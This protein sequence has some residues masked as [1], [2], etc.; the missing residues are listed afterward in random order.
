MG[1]AISRRITSANSSAP[2]AL[3]SDR[4]YPRYSSSSSTL[5]SAHYSMG[6]DATPITTC[7]LA[8]SPVSTPIRKPESVYSPQSSVPQ[9]HSRWQQQSQLQRQEVKSSTVKHKAKAGFSSFLS[10]SGCKMLGHGPGVD[11][12]TPIPVSVPPPQAKVKT[13]QKKKEQQKAKVKKATEGSVRNVAETRMEISWPTVC[14]RNPGLLPSAIAMGYPYPYPFP[15]STVP[16]DPDLVAT[17]E[18]S[19]GGDYGYEYECLVEAGKVGPRGGVRLEIRPGRNPRWE[20]QK[21]E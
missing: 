8:L 1:C 5:G 3:S 14:H 4:V 17:A 20:G 15:L 7:T 19:A 11:I 9:A 18:K 13:A 2:Q 21:E 12:I 10:G 16:S 6:G